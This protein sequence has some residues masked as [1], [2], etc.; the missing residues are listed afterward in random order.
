MNWERGVKSLYFF[1][2]VVWAALWT[3]LVFLTQAEHSI[4]TV[5]IVGFLLPLVLY[6]GAIWI[7]SGFRSGS[8]KMK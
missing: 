5:F 3:L 4:L 6:I 2:W 1:L 7:A 8:D